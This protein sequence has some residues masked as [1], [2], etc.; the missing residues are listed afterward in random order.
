MVYP[1]V[2]LPKISPVLTLFAAPELPLE[3]YI[4]QPT[5]FVQDNLEKML[6]DWTLPTAWV[7][8]ILQK[9]RFSLSTRSNIVEQEKQRLRERF[10]RFGVEVAFD[11]KEQGDLADL[12]DPRNGQPL[13]SHPGVLN[14][15]DVK[16]VSTLLGFPTAL[17]D[18]TCMI[19][20][21]W[22]DA[23]YPSVMLS[24]A[25]PKKIKSVLETSAERFQWQVS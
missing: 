20:P 25:D 24:S 4:C 10:M 1:S 15:D 9:A 2:Q 5:P 7:V 16:V 21:H 19:H 11:L 13:L 23:V 12:I 8:I 22:G 14:H 6:P 17:G 3:V 18:C